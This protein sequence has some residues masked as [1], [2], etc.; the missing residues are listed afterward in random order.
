MNLGRQAPA[1]AEG[2][3]VPMVPLVHLDGPA[4]YSAAGVAAARCG[5]DPESL[6]ASTAQD[7]EA[8][9]NGR[10]LRVGDYAGAL[11]TRLGA[12]TA[13]ALAAHDI[14]RGR[15][16]GLGAIPASALAAH[17]IARVRATWHQHPSPC[18]AMPLTGPSFG[19]RGRGEA[20]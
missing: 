4:P 8:A 16:T 15:A 7:L 9:A 19:G 2:R 14:A 10:G 6:T 18:S 1:V 5:E 3:R 17:A 13:S 20:A 11:A 12:I